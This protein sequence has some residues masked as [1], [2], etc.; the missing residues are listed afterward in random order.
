MAPKYKK[1]IELMVRKPDRDAEEA[2][3]TMVDCPFCTM[4]GPETEL[5][6]VGCQKQIPFDVATG[7]LSV[8]SSGVCQSLWLVPVVGMG[9]PTLLM[10]CWRETSLSPRR[11]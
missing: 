11:G 7:A 5:Q 8:R 2:E 10:P 1:K 9:C 6:C 4:P 3:E